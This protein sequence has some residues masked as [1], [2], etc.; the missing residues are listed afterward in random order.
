MCLYQASLDLV[1]FNAAGEGVYAVIT[2]PR[3]ERFDLPMLGCLYSVRLHRQVSVRCPKGS[4]NVDIQCDL[5]VI[6]HQMYKNHH[7]C[8]VVFVVVV[9]IMSIVGNCI[10]TALVAMQNEQKSTT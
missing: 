3:S 7:R 8:D 1:N 5:Q 10:A 6:L 2:Y 9:I 4:V